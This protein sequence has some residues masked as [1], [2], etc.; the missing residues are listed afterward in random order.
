VLGTAG[1]EEQQTTGKNDERCA[2]Q[3]GRIGDAW[4]QLARRVLQQLEVLAIAQ[5]QPIL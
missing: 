2:S 4:S 1:D 3:D 5:G